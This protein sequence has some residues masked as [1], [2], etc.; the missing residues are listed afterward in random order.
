M[1][2]K[3]T[4]KLLMFFAL[5]L[6]ILSML[7]PVVYSNS[8]EPPGFTI[9]VS[10]PPD[11]LSLSI[12]FS[13]G[14]I[15]NPIVLQKEQ[16]AWESYYRFF[17]GMVGSKRPSFEGVTIIVQSNE[18]NFEYS[19]PESSFSQYNNLLTLHLENRSITEGQSFVRLFLLVSLR[20]VLTLF[21][22]GLMLFAFGYRSKKSWIAF[23]VINLVTQG[24]LN[25]LL[26]GPNL[27]YYWIIGFIFF[28]IVI[29]IVEMIAFTLLLKEHKKS[30]AIAYTLAANITSLI[31]GGLFISYLPI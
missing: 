23:V 21:I 8:A 26:S 30:R 10:F 3:K 31:L 16:K 5:I 14:S 11:D 25:T 28:E 1:I 12:R 4:T 15:S 27:V 18:I 29:F 24:V 7:T 9:I 17:Y 20:V 22:E 19:L 6:L 13:D 2:H